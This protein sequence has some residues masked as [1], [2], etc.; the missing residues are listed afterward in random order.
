VIQSVLHLWHCALLDWEQPRDLIEA[1]EDLRDAVVE[2]T[3]LTRLDTCSIEEVIEAAEW[4]ANEEEAA[5]AVDEWRPDDLGELEQA[6]LRRMFDHG[7][8]LREPNAA[9]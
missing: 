7:N 4:L 6:L 8:D 2:A 1:E 5:D 3:G 9:E